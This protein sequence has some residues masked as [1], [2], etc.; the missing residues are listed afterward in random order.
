MPADAPNDFLDLSIEI[1]AHELAM[2]AAPAAVRKTQANPVPTFQISA[3]VSIRPS[4]FNM[5][6]TPSQSIVKPNDTIDTHELSTQ[7][8]TSS[9]TVASTSAQQ[10]QRSRPSC[11]YIKTEKKDAS[12]L[13]ID[14]SM[15]SSS[16][17]VS[18]EKMTSP[19]KYKSRNKDI[20]PFDVHVQN[21]L[22]DD[23]HFIDYIEQLDNVFV[24]TRIRPIE[25]NSD[26][27]LDTST[28]E[29]DEQI[30]QGS[31]GFVYR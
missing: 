29:I 12:I 9:L 28:I 15:N 27:I 18:R 23:I 13:V 3:P 16:G 22:L 5:N 7:S 11:A 6:E 20:D 19:F 10:T 1:D 25:V 14:D 17:T 24:T 30:G 26:L 31:F 8:T 2:F 21:A 4:Q